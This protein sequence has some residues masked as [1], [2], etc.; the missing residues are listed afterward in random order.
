MI[1][2]LKN[3]VQSVKAS[4]QTPKSVRKQRSFRPTV[5][6]LEERVALYGPASWGHGAYEP[7]IAAMN[8]PL[9]PAQFNSALNNFLAPIFRPGAYQTPP[10]AMV[11]QYGSPNPFNPIF[12]GLGFGGGFSGFGYGNPMRGALGGLGSA[13]GF[14]GGYGGG[15]FGMVSNPLWLTG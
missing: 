4:L 1:R 8:P 6:G 9:P 11:P 14:G 12:G 2:A 10:Y 7:W 5:D 13:P 3:L 15:M